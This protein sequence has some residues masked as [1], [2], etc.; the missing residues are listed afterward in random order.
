MYVPG[1]YVYVADL[2]QRLL[3]RVAGAD[4]ATSSGGAFQILTLEPLE[5][6][7]RSWP[8][9]RLI[10][11]DEAVRPAVARDLWRARTRRGAA[12]ASPCRGMA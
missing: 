7:W 9:T 5:G 11:L 8:D 2:P 3:C 6:P 1:D 12:G 10:R 4:S